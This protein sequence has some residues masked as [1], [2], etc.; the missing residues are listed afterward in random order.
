MMASASLGLITIHGVQV[1][2]TP[3][4]WPSCS[5]AG[6][7]ASSFTMAGPAGPSVAVASCSSVGSMCMQYRIDCS[8]C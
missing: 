8:A 7:R 4:F 6:V 5:G 3:A 2:P 1:S